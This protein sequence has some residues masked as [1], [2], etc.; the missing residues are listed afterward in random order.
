MYP[1]LTRTPLGYTY[2]CLHVPQFKEYNYQKHGKTL[3]AKTNRCV[4]VSS[5]CEWSSI[6]QGQAGGT[7]ESVII[8]LDGANKKSET[9]I[10][11]S[12]ASGRGTT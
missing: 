9:H 2:L 10:W 8:N 3:T 6:I 7:N 1:P 4:T 5:K 11:A 12:L